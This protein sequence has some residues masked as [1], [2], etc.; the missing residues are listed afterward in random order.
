MPVTMIEAGPCLVTQV[1]KSDKDSYSAVQVGFDV[2][3]KVNKPLAGHLKKI[4]KTGQAHPRFLKEFRLKDV[5]KFKTGQY[6]TADVFVKGDQVTVTGVSKGRG[7]AG[8]VKRHGFKG[9][10]ASHGHKDQLRMPGSIGATDAA[11]VFKGVRMGGRMGNQSVT[12]KN[13]EIV[14]VDPEKNLLYIKGALP[15]HRNSLLFIKAEGEME[16][17]ETLEKA[18]PVKMATKETGGTASVKEEAPVEP[19]PEAVKDPEEVLADKEQP[20]ESTEEPKADEK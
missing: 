12:I 2:R 9:G 16:L 15:G 11:R 18:T 14:E 19:V 6:I 1:K 3:K 8:V 17:K 20:A 7:F 4:V 13:L 10:P 5:S